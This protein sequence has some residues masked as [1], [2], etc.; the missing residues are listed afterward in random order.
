MK[1]KKSR[2][3]MVNLKRVIRIIT[4][5]WKGLYL[6]NS[7]EHTLREDVILFGVYFMSVLTINVIILHSYYTVTCHACLMNVNMGSFSATLLCS[8][9]LN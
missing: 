3:K 1:N 6:P 7:V 8:F 2:N 4:F 5:T 9:I